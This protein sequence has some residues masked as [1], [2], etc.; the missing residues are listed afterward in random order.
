M[1]ERSGDY[2]ESYGELE[3]IE[4]GFVVIIVAVVWG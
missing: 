4:L 2:S 3:E 1:R